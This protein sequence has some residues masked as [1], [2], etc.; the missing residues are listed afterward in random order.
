M[1]ALLIFGLGAAAIAAYSAG[2]KSGVDARPI[3]APPPPPP[4]PAPQVTHRPG[5]P[6][7][8]TTPSNILE[9]KRL[10]VARGFQAALVRRQKNHPGESRQASINAVAAQLRAR[11]IPLEKP[12]PAL[13]FWRQSEQQIAD[14]MA[15]AVNTISGYYA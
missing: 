9:R 12:N 5:S 13:A 4:T 1:I 8:P 3:P 14:Q 2:Q 15:T 6:P 7:P 10:I 11:K